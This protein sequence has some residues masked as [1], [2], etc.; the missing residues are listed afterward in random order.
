MKKPHAPFRRLLALL[1]VLALIA[2]PLPLPRRNAAVLPKKCPEHGLL[3]RAL[4]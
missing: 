3:L 2:S 4:L 1:L